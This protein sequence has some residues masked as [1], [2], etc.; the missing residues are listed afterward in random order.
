LELKMLVNFTDICNTYCVAIWHN[1][2]P[3]F[4]VIWYIFTVLVCCSK[5]NM[6][7]PFSTLSKL[8][9]LKNS[10]PSWNVSLR[11]PRAKKT[12]KFQLNILPNLLKSFFSFLS[13][14]C[15]LSVL[16]AVA[17]EEKLFLR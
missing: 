11:S 6:A 4:V 3:Y 1:V 15:K 5:K 13:L 14:L 17:C 2:R 16:H 10:K 12:T 9:S 8:F 7:S